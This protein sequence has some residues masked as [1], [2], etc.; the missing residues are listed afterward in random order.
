MTNIVNL[1]D[2]RFTIPNKSYWID[3]L[4]F[5][6]DLLESG[7]IIEEICD[8]VGNVGARIVV[9]RGERFAVHQSDLKS[10]VFVC[11]LP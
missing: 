9:H 8:S 7:Q 10:E 3:D 2:W 1:S 11:R 5:M 4:Q 6:A